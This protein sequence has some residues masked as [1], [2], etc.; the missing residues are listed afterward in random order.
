MQAA[1]EDRLLPL[2][3]GQEDAGE[4]LG[5]GK[6][7]NGLRSDQG[8]FQRASSQGSLLTPNLPGRHQWMR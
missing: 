8:P 3:A 6:E 2:A 7:Q 4:Q 5:L 1:A